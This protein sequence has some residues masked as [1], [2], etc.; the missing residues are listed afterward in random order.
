MDFVV[1]ECIC[2]KPTMPHPMASKNIRRAEL[3]VD[4]IDDE[5]DLSAENLD[6][7]EDRDFAGINLYVMFVTCVEAFHQQ[8]LFVIVCWWQSSV[9]SSVQ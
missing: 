5:D 2:Q 6:L 8:D 4:H 3:A 9:V 7:N 1:A